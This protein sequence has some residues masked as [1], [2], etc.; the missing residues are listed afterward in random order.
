MSA[1]RL[2]LFLMQRIT[3]TLMNVMKGTTIAIPS[4][5]EIL[6]PTS[7]YHFRSKSALSSDFRLSWI[8]F[9]GGI[10]VE[11]SIAGDVPK[12]FAFSCT[13][14]HCESRQEKKKEKEN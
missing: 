2:R 4:V 9:K 6:F 5:I 12:I 11:I 14:F 7:L 10:G 3:H 8:C 1:F 13:N